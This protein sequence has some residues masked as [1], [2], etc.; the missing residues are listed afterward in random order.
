M[1]TEIIQH[2]V[3]K[4]WATITQLPAFVALSRFGWIFFFHLS[5]GTSRVKNFTPKNKKNNKDNNK[6]NSKNNSNLSVLMFYFWPDQSLQACR[7]SC[8]DL[9]F[10][11]A[12]FSQHLK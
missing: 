7:G 9:Y 1:S 6:N 4:S 12:L 3:V 2:Q 11:Q 5:T 8:T 10:F